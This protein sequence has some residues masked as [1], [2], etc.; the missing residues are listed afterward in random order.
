[1]NQEAASADHLPPLRTR[2][3]EARS[4]SF[5]GLVGIEDGVGGAPSLHFLKKMD[6]A[7]CI[8]IVLIGVG[9]S[10]ATPGQRGG[11]FQVQS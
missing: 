6:K 3:A 2:E 8:V 10:L 9:V 11:P 1:M 7:F 5:W 4:V